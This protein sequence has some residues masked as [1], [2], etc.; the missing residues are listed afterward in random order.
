MAKNQTI[1]LRPEQ[2]VA[3]NDA[4]AALKKIPNYVPSN[5][6]YSMTNGTALQAARIS[7]SEAEAQASAAYD[8][9]RD[10]AVKA[11]WDVHNFM[12]GVKNQVAAQFGDDSNEIQSLG[13]KK[14][15]EYKKP[16]GKA[17]K[18]AATAQ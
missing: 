14:K 1:R 13:I 12:L 4:F 17:K 18:A 15:S 11:E 8:T 9:A 6:A 16:A 5:S 10:N 7:T 2:V 3:D